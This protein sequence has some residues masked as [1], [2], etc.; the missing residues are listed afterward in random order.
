MLTLAQNRRLHVI[1]ITT[2]GIAVTIF[3]LFL[4]VATNAKRLLH[5]VGAQ[6]QVIVFLTDDIQPAQRETIATQLQEFAAAQAVRY[7]SKDQAWQDF[8]SWFQGGSLSSADLPHNPLPAS[9]MLQLSP[10]AANDTAIAPFIQRIARLSG[11]EEVQYGAE[12][13]RSF[14]T[15][16]WLLQKLSFVGSCLL[17]LGVMCIVANT[18]RLTVYTR[19]HEIEVMQLV[20]ATEGFIKG[21]F[22][23]IGLLQSWLGTL[24]A[25]GIAAGLYYTVL[26]PLSTTLS[27]TFGLGP[28][29]FLSKLLLGSI[30]I[31]NLVLGYLGSTLA[32]RRALRVLSATH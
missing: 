13:R 22:I 8:T 30:V 29:Q 11:V 12:W 9:Y 26:D 23:L 1:A 4:L 15:A 7:V 6:A 27:A 14:Q 20:G 3:I 28:L 19:L 32:L 21:P 5:E 24:L 10:H 25:L 2:I 31:G 16:V 17:G 18:M